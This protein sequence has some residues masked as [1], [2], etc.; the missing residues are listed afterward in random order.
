MDLS[1]VQHEHLM[2]KLLVSNPCNIQSKTNY[3]NKPNDIPK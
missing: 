1:R 3:N 2:I